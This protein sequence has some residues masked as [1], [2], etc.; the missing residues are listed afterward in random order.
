MFARP[1]LKL[2]ELLYFP[3]TDAYSFVSCIYIIIFSFL[4]NCVFCMQYLL[5]FGVK[6]IIIDVDRGVQ[7]EGACAPPSPPPAK[8]SGVLVQGFRT[9]SA[10][11]G[12][13]CAGAW[14]AIRLQL[15]RVAMC[16]V[17]FSVQ[18]SSQNLVAS[19]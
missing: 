17:M 9:S 8:F 10:L 1:E 16:L 14:T 18:F 13:A 12:Y 3:F 11:P 5:P 7:G 15:S 6:R 2:N 4:H 19:G